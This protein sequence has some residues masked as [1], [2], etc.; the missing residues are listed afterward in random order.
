MS[1]ASTA[2]PLLSTNSAAATWPLSAAQCSGVEPQ[3]LFSG[4]PSGHCG[5][6]ADH[7]AEADAPRGRRKLWAAPL[8]ARSTHK[9]MMNVFDSTASNCAK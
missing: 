1:L 7:G 5:L 4:N 6:P 2:P 9:R 3:A 8:Y